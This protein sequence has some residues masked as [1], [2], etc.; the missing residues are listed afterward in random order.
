MN[1][2]LLLLI[3]LVIIFLIAGGLLTQASYYIGPKQT[4][5]GLQKAYSI[6]T[7][8]SVL[9][10]LT[11]AAIIFGIVIYI[12]YYAEGG[13][14]IQAVQAYQKYQSGGYSGF[15]WFLIICVILAIIVIGVFAAAAAVNIASFAGYKMNNY[16]YGAWE[17]CTITSILCIVSIFI[18]LVALFYHWYGNEPEVKVKK[19]P[20]KQTELASINSATAPVYSP[21]YCK[22]L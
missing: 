11:V 15:T 2:P 5:A 1:W 7:W 21:R 13:A 3:L 22:C 12:W 14:E 9:T 20:I 6:T 18:I 10:W 8:V 17:D 16:Y 19:V 4:D